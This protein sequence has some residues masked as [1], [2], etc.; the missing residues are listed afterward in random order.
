[1]G[2]FTDKMKEPTILMLVFVIVCVIVVGGLLV[3]VMLNNLPD[4]R[5]NVTN[6]TSKLEMSNNNM[7]NL[8]KAVGTEGPAYKQLETR[9]DKNVIPKLDDLD[10]DLGKQTKNRDDQTKRL[11]TRLKI[12]DHVERWHRERVYVDRV[13]QELTTLGVGF[14]KAWFVGAFLGATQAYRDKASL[15]K[16]VNKDKLIDIDETEMNR[17]HSLLNQAMVYIQTEN[18]QVESADFS[19]FTKNSALW[20]TWNNFVLFLKSKISV[21]ITETPDT[22]QD[23]N[24]GFY[25]SK[26]A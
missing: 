21:V 22:D 17:L 6:N 25:L 19:Q 1:M 24:W 18:G 4:I 5:N 14:R 9:L 10:K 23:I 26:A 16:I 8:L 3:N 13:V 15:S 12:L 11:E 2:K 7:S 20:G